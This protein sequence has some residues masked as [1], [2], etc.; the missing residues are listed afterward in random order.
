MMETLLETVWC[1]NIFLIGF[2]FQEFFEQFNHVSKDSFRDNTAE[3][4]IHT[5]GFILVIQKQ[6]K[7]WT[8]SPVAT[9]FHATW[10]QGL[11][12]IHMLLNNI[13]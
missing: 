1:P 7:C 6:L 3:K 2:L 10:Y 12:H 9:A 11:C 13:F 5:K 4:Y 8:T